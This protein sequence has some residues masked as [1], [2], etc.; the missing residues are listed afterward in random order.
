[1]IAIYLKLSEDENIDTENDSGAEARVSANEGE[2]DNT[3]DD[4]GGKR[5]YKLIQNQEKVQVNG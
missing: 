5:R 2:E 1:M 3:T 4:E